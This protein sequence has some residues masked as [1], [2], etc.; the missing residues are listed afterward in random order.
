MHWLLLLL[1][2]LLLL[3]GC[4]ANT[5]RD[6]NTVTIAL[7][8][9]P[10]NLDPRIGTDASSQRLFELM[11][12]SLVKKN[13]QFAIEPDLA[14]RWDT[15]D[16]LTYIFHLRSDAFFHDGRR[17][18]SK[19]IV[20]T[21]RSMMDGSIRTPK[22][23]TFRLVESI[24]AP[25]EATVVFKLKEPFAALLWN[26]TLGGVGIVP[27]GS[28]TAFGQN[29]IGSG[30]FKFVRYIRDGEVVLA[31]NDSYYGEKPNVAV[32]RFRIIPEAIVTAL[33][34]RKGTVDVAPN[35]L[36]ADM[37]EVLRGDDDLQVMEADGTRYQYI[38]FNLK[39]PVFKDLRV[40]QAFAHG[41]DRE[42]IIK[43]LWRD[44]ARLATGVI[45]PE[46]WT[47]EP[48][49]KTYAYDPA[50]ARQLLKDAGQA[51]LSFTW[52]TSTDEVGRLIASVL[53]QQLREIGVRMEIRSNEFATFM[54]DVVKG[55]FQAYS[56]RWIGGNNDPDIFN[57]IFHSKF[58]PPNGANRSYYSNPRVDELIELAQ[59]ETD[60]EK[61]RTAYQEIQRIVAEELPY[62]SLYYLDNVVV[63]NKR[64]SG[65]KIT[66]A[67]NYDFLTSLRIFAME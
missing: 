51:N 64:I 19:D 37:I 34:L 1:V 31:R 38:A 43:Y 6:P 17:L 39:D 60:T 26:L 50:R 57:L 32:V 9:P 13:D 61:R 40:R 23:G 18:T 11:F 14:L 52:R 62:I 22:A 67:G 29:P 46:H 3:P 49:V 58:T 28:D 44:Q 20:F 47:Y 5:A 36:P 16:P 48:N 65:M 12:S 55:N 8:V 63:F 2:A 27:D 41:I 33:E 42:K 56:L 66:P 7:D 53:Q 25:D 45:P 10:T 59:R 30:Q 21:F 15:P 4:G 54:A 24:E 35:I